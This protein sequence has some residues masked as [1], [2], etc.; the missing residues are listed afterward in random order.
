MTAQHARTAGQDA[1]SRFRA[2]QG[3]AALALCVLDEQLP[4]FRFRGAEDVLTAR[5]KLADQLGTFREAIRAFA[6]E[7]DESPY[8]ATFQQKV[9]RVVAAKVRP[10][11]TELEREIRTSRD[12]FVARCVRNVRTGSVPI[13]AS[14][15]V[16]L[17]ASVIIGLSAGVVTV[18]AALETYLDIRAKKRHGLS[19]FLKP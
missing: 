12:G 18:E 2:P 10:A 17:P 15:F 19:L 8:D 7:I 1:A 5:A 11:L 14:I 13:L 4:R 3:S 6:A 9:E 16:G